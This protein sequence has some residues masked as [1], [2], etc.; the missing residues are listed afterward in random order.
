MISLFL[1]SPESFP[2]ADM[3]SM[4]HDLQAIAHIYTHKTKDVWPEMSKLIDQRI[5]LCKRSARF[6]IPHYVRKESASR[7]NCNC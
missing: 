5:S 6:N 2:T 3:T 1:F 4:L 7:D